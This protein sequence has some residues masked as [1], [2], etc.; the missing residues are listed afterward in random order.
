MKCLVPFQKCELCM[1]LC[2]AVTQT[3]LLT[4]ACAQKMESSWQSHEVSSIPIPGLRAPFRRSKWFFQV[5][6]LLSGGTSV[7]AKVSMPPSLPHVG[8]HHRSYSRQPLAHSHIS[9]PPPGAP[10]HGTSNLTW[11]LGTFLGAMCEHSNGFHLQIFQTDVHLKKKITQISQPIC[12]I[13]QFIFDFSQVVP[14]IP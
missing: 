4:V 10:E 13:G 11:P 9:Q 14:Q 5:T 8:L 12:K 7:W 3:A 1:C 6:Q 2:R